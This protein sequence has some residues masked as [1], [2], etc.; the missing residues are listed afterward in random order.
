MLKA[1]IRMTTLV[2]NRVIEKG[3]LGATEITI[4]YRDT[5]QADGYSRE[6][7]LLML[8]EI[9]I[10]E[11]RQQW[12]VPEPIRCGF[13]GHCS[14][15]EKNGFCPAQVLP[16]G[17]K[18]PMQCLCFTHELGLKTAEK[19]AID[20]IVSRARAKRRPDSDFTIS[21]S[22]ASSEALNG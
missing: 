10:N 12:T 17:S 15:C 21:P 8:K 6:E 9:R 1:D 18:K 5:N 22:E 20:E 11:E 4:V 2:G 7:L 3:K 16:P 14:P 19:K 13:C